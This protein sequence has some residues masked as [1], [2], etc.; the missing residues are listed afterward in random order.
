MSLTEK[1]ARAD[2][3]VDNSGSSEQMAAQICDLV[4]RLNPN[5]S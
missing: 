5:D 4:R 1:A 2:Y 3:V